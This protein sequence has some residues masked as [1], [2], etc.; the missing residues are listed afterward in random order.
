MK[1]A[2]RIFSFMLIFVF[3]ASL[4]F[5]PQ[6]GVRATGGGGIGTISLASLGTAYFQNFDTLANAGST[7]VIS[8]NGWYLYENGTSAVAEG[9]Y[10]TDTG[11]STT[12][13]TYSYGAAASNERA[14]G[15]LLSGT[16]TSTIGASFTNNTGSAIG[17]LLIAYTGEEWRLGAAGRA[18]SLNFQYSTDATSLIT[19]TWIDFS[20]L[21]FST[22]D[23]VTTGA[24]NGNVA[25]DRTALSST[26]SGLNILNGSPFWIR[27]TDYNP[28]GSD[29]GLA[30]DDFSLTP[31]ACIFIAFHQRRHPAE[32]NADT[33]LFSFTV[34]LSSPAPA[35]GVTFD[36]ATADGTATVADNDYVARSLSGQTIAEGSSSFTFDVTV[37]GDTNTEPT[38][39]FSVNVTNVSRRHIERRYGSGNHH[40]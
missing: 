20:A 12:G 18:D 21:N 35:G 34:S 38:E 13:D 28:S 1:T 29:D 37:N 40:Q 3:M 4:V 2:N 6:K 30:V 9:Q 26:I 14:F 24:K 10:G 39:T 27:W 23:Q 33:S 22:P 19:G 5:V 16:I 17:N 11:S 31:T 8:I 7:N 36:I 15:T 25:P 32:G